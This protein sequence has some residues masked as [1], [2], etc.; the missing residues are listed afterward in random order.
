M[1]GVEAAGQHSCQGVVEG[2][3]AAIVKNQTAKVSKGLSGLQSQDFHRQ[4]SHDVAQ[5]DAEELGRVGF[6][7]LSIEGLL[8]R[9]GFPQLIALSMEIG[10]ALDSLGGHRSPHR[11]AQAQRRDQALA[12][13]QSELF[14]PF[15]QHGGIK[16]RLE[17]LG[18]SG[19]LFGIHP[20]F[21]SRIKDFGGWMDLA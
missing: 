20:P 2:Q 18:H 13:G 5:G 17:L 6:K 1:H 16:D 19:N 12:L 4:L 8:I 15:I 14:A 9:L 10:N 21:L 3:R 7:Q 11:E